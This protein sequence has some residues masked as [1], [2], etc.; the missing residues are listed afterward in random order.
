MI[1]TAIDNREAELRVG[2]SNLSGT[3]DQMKEQALRLMQ[4]SSRTTMLINYLVASA[5]SKHKTFPSG[6]GRPDLETVYNETVPDEKV[7]A[8]ILEKLSFV[9]ENDGSGSIAAKCAK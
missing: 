4:F 7:A 1:E 3:P 2:L 6:Q 5:M 9:L 8:I